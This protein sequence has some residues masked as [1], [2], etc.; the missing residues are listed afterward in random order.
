MKSWLNKALLPANTRL[1]SLTEGLCASFYP[2][3]QLHKFGNFKNGKTVGWYLT[4]KH[5]ESEGEARNEQG[6]GGTA[7]Y[8][9][10]TKG[11]REL[12]D[13]WSDNTRPE[14]KEFRS[15]VEG[16]IADI[17]TDQNIK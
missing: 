4:I 6:S 12:F 14:K 3:G 10:Y 8:E 7:D 1:G 5:G 16:W 9:I 13:A 11:T 17:S 15:W 2:D